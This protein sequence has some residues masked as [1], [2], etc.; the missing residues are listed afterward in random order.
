V[1][2][3]PNIKTMQKTPFINNLAILERRYKHFDYLQDFPCE[4]Q[5]CFI[6]E[7]TNF[8][9]LEPDYFLGF[10]MDYQVEGEQPT[11]DHFLFLSERDTDSIQTTSCLV[12]ALDL[13]F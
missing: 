12:P 5:G 4:L 8:G 11:P 1:T 10:I 13:F 3:A 6:N 9:T 7:A 2:A